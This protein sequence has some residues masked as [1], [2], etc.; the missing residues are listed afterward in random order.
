MAIFR[1]P[2]R[3]TAQPAENITR[4]ST[5]KSA[6]LEQAEPDGN[7]HVDG[8]YGAGSIL[9]FFGAGRIAAVGTIK[10]LRSLASS[11]DNHGVGALYVF[12]VPDKELHAGFF[13]ESEQLFR[14]GVDILIA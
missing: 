8:V 6:A 9:R 12:A 14:Y 13:G 4:L 2:S 5:L 11:D 3:S 10:S 1:R 7:S